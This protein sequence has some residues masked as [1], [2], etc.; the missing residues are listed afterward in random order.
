MEEIKR[1]DQ[2]LLKIVSKNNSLKTKLRRA[3]FTEKEIWGEPVRRVVKLGSE[4]LEYSNFLTE[5]ELADFCN[6]YNTADF[7]SSPKMA[8]AQVRAKSAEVFM[9]LVIGQEDIL[10]QIII[11]T[12]PKDKQAEDI[13]GIETRIDDL[14]YKLNFVE[15]S[16]LFVD[17]KIDL[18]VDSKKNIT[19]EQKAE[20]KRTL[21][22]EFKRLKDLYNYTRE[23]FDGVIKII[24][25]T[26]KGYVTTSE[27]ADM[28]AKLKEIERMESK[29]SSSFV[30]KNPT[31][32]QKNNDELEEM[33]THKR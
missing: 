1:K 9:T 11:P 20:L 4:V 15:Y 7:I 30:I 2:L 31:T 28:K 29:I 17:K 8:P 24:T 33:L 16:L 26:L 19:P 12:L 13:K 23:Y 14:T 27:L 6:L 21:N 10:H 25:E 3:S 22:K 18:F 5:Y 32:V